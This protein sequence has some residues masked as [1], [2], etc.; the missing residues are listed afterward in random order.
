MTRINRAV[1]VR[2]ARVEERV[3]AAEREMAL[4]RA[5]LSDLSKNA[6]SRNEWSTNHES[7]KDKYDALSRLV[8]MGVGMALLI[9]VAVYFIKK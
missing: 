9:S 8:Y 3:K 5:A 2:L 6:V 1:V 7:L 4:E